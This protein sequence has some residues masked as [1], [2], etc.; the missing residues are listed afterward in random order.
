MLVFYCFFVSFVLPVI[1]QYKEMKKR[2]KSFVVITIMKF[3][4]FSSSSFIII[5][6]RRAFKYAILCRR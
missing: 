6:F 2:K 3:N 5:I 1:I 4:F